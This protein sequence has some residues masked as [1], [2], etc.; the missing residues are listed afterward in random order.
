MNN[1]LKIVGEVIYFQGYRVAD[2]LSSASVPHTVME[3]F[4]D[5]IYDLGAPEEIPDNQYEAGYDD[6]YLAGRSDGEYE[7]YNAAMMEVEEKNNKPIMANL[8]ATPAEG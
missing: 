4:K 1:D 8:K 6:G 7:G 5:Y 3:T 2:L